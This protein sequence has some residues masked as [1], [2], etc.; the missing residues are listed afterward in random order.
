MKIEIEIKDTDATITVDGRTYTATSDDPSQSIY[1]LKP[2]LFDHCL[3]EIVVSKLSNVVWPVMKI[4][5]DMGLTAWEK[6]D[7]DVHDEAEEYF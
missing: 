2:R 1:T 4:Q 7:D 6:L 3:G 5:S